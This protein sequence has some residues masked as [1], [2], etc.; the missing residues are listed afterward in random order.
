MLIQCLMCSKH[1]FKVSVDNYYSGE[2]FKNKNHQLKVYVIDYQSFSL[3]TC[4]PTSVLLSMRQIWTFSMEG[5]PQP[6]ASL[7]AT[8]ST[9]KN[10]A[11]ALSHFLLYESFLLC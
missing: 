6:W 11:L 10:W 7:W 4:F 8:R 5:F 2:V 1:L 9:N 3:Y